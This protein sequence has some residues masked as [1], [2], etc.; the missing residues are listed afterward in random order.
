[1]NKRKKRVL[2]EFVWIIIYSL[3]PRGLACKV[4]YSPLPGRR[5]RGGGEEHGHNLF[6]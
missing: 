2:Q 6:L 5:G 4:T 1:M 3:S